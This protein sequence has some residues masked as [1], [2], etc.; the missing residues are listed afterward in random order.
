M[1]CYSINGQLLQRTHEKGTECFMNV[2]LMKDSLGFEHVAYGN[3]A[4]EVIFRA[5]PFLDHDVKSPVAKSALVNRVC[6]S[7]N[8]RFLV[9]GCSDGELAVIT[10]PQTVMSS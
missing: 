2:T 8:V 10:D 1:Y 5:M 9:T 4:G 3:Q 6:P 7:R